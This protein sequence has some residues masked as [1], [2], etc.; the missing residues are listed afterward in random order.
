MGNRGRFSADL[1]LPSKG[2]TVANT[3]STASG[4]FVVLLG[5]LSCTTHTWEGQR[6]DRHRGMKDRRH[7]QAVP[8]PQRAAGHLSG[9]S[10]SMRVENVA[11]PTAT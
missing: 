8:L 2:C 6:P 1:V 11:A 3:A 7:T 4:L 9:M 10:H 5:Q